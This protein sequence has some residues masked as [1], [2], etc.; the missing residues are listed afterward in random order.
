MEEGLKEL[1]LREVRE[2]VQEESEEEQHKAVA[3]KLEEVEEVAALR[4]Q[5]LT[6][7]MQVGE[8]IEEEMETP[9]LALHGCQP[10]VVVVREVAEAGEVAKAE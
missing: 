1:K 3:L 7:K 5:L 6:T 8:E 10:E 9:E 4:M 2:L